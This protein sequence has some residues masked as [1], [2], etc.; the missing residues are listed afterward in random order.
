[1]R[2]FNKFILICESFPPSAFGHS[3]RVAKLCKYLPRVS[4]WI[5]TV[6]CGIYQENTGYDK[7]LLDEIPKEIEVYR[8]KGFESNVF[9]NKIKETFLGKI[10]FHSRKLYTFPDHKVDW[11]RN[12]FKFAIKKFGKGDKFKLIFAS[13][14]P[15]SSYIAGFWLSR[16]WNNL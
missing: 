4:N 11:A 10:I 14:P 2:K 3:Q 6:L 13:G 9:Y 8:I 5:P 7:D 1:M 12:V 16:Y 15:R